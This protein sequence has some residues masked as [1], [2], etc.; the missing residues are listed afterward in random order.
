MANLS[1]SE[2]TQKLKKYRSEINSQLASLALV[3]S[4][5]KTERAA[6]RKSEERTAA[7]E[8]AQELAQT[9]A[10]Q[11]QRQVHAQIASVVSRCIETVF[12][13]PYRFNILFERKRGRTEARLVFERDGLEVD[14]LSAAGGGVVNVAAFGLRLAC[15]LLARPTLRR[16]LILDEPFRFVSVGLRG[17]VRALLEGLSEEMGVQ[18]IMVTHDP[19]LQAGTVIDLGR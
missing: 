5:I 9:V 19:Q 1:P 14:P 17:R 8:E 15:L 3:R 7:I 6:L 16:V 18:I 4:Q 10:A 13:E 12:D 2:P 11:I